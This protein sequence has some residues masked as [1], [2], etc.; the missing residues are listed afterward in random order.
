MER[1]KAWQR[2]F[3]ANMQ[4]IIGGDAQVVASSLLCDAENAV[5]DG[6]QD[7]HLDYLLTADAA[8]KCTIIVAERPDGDRAQPYSL[9]LYPRSHTVMM[10]AAK[11]HRWSVEDG[12]EHSSEELD[13]LFS[14][15]VPFHEPVRL[16]L[17]PGQVLI[18]H[19]CL[20]HGGRLAMSP[21]HCWF[22]FGA[23]AN[24][25]TFPAYSHMQATQPSG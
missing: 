8:Q 11:Y 24:A 15:M 19:G 21:F 17:Q 7:P 14:S 1:G 20:V 12:F 25:R 22:A 13:R 23:A 6:V 3:L 18:C 2:S 5:D 10:D 16:I 4:H 9:Y